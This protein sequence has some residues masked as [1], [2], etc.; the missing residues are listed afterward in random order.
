MKH[1]LGETSSDERMLVQEWLLADPANQAY[2]DELK[3]VWDTT[4]QLSVTSKVDENKAWQRFRQR[5]QNEDTDLQVPA[6][7]V[8]DVKQ[9][10]FSWRKIA[11]AVVLLVGLTAAAYWIYNDRSSVTV[12]AQTGDNTLS[13]TLP[14]G[15]VVTLNRE[16]SISYPDEFKGNKRPVKL[17]GEA[18][19]DVK[20]DKKKPFIISVNDIEVKVVGTSFNIRSVNGQTEVIVET[21]I[22]Q[23]TRNGK[24]Y[25]LRPGSKYST[26]GNDF[27]ITE[28]TDNLYNYY[29]SRI[30]VCDETPL[31]KLVAGI[32]RAYD[33]KI[34]F[35]NENA[36]KDLRINIT[37]KNEPIERVMELISA[38]LNIKISK[39]DDGYVMED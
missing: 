37:L 25:E 19:F 34:V 39:T 14:D 21:G 26:A 10:Q 30:F 31:L 33:V 20:T 16:S 23:V 17:K 2:F 18:F 12:I 13:E 32:E 3:K 22:V 6:P 5:I 27:T 11:A 1:L 24:S 9:K 28:V 8:V 35:K 36:L 4:L 29:R 7:V 38:T 15:S